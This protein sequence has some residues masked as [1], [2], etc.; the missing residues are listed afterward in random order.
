[1][2]AGEELHR[3]NEI[4]DIYLFF[5]R[6]TEGMRDFRRILGSRFRWLSCRAI[7][8]KEQRT[9]PSAQESASWPEYGRK[10]R[11]KARPTGRAAC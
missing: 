10:I 3:K 8:E 6:T 5:F 1:M 2:F 11:Y 9:R 4:L 7:L